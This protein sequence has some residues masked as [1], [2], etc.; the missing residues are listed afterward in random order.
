[1]NQSEIDAVVKLRNQG[2]QFGDI[3]KRLGMSV[4]QAKRRWYART[5]L[6]E[7]SIE[8]IA[9]AAKERAIPADYGIREETTN[10]EDDQG[11]ESWANPVPAEEEEDVGTYKLGG[12]A[13]DRKILMQADEI[14]RLRRELKKVHREQLAEEQIVEIMHGLLTAADGPPK[15]TYEYR[16][17]NGGTTPETPITAWADWHCGETVNLEQVGGVNEYNFAIMDRRINN[18]ITRTI[19]LCENHGP[20]NYEGIIINLVGD[21]VS[22][23][24][25]DELQKTDEDTPIE[26]VLRVADRLV[27]GLQTMADH[28]GKVYA[29]A[30]CG[31]HGRNTHKPEY[32]GYYKKNWD[33]MAYAIVQKRLNDMKDDRIQIDFRPAN[34]IDYRSYNHRYW[35]CHGDMIGA[36]G[37]D[38]IIGAIGPI[39]RGEFKTRGR[40]SSMNRNFDTMVMGHYHQS[41]W[42]PRAIVSNTI[43][44]Y[45]EYAKNKL[46]VSPTAPSQPLWFSH[47][48][49]GITSRWDVMVEEP[50]DKPVPAWVTVFD[51][52]A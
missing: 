44:G 24:I 16:T 33:Y 5:K 45:C 52:A 46:N 39:M 37:G 48:K 38:G 12:D 41:L 40:A 51:D 14:T 50:E 43:K 49:Y 23:G 35:L 7:F 27:I 11:L 6:P 25:H 30:V 32:K 19:D 36:N 18:L 10:P 3:A 4:D 20:G 21:M 47:P 26:C 2:L 15:W 22:G 31:N 17:K 1:M 8:K 29:P 42:L 13:K 28:F 9:K 34:E